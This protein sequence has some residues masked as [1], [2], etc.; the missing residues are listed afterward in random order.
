MSEIVKDPPF[1]NAVETAIY[2]TFIMNK[3][4]LIVFQSVISK[5]H[6]VFESFD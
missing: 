4:K 3:Y 5:Q 1:N 6:E 2:I